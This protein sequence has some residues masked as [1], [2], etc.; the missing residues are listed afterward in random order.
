MVKVTNKSDEVVALTGIVAFYPHETR[1]IPEHLVDMVLANQ[2][3]ILV[4][5]EKHVGDIDVA[6]TKKPKK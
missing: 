2:D 6:N 1:D 4:K 5:D 3:M